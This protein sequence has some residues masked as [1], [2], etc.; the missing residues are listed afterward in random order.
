MLVLTRLAKTV[1]LRI[2]QLQMLANMGEELARQQI[3]A[4]QGVYQ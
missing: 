3:R 2:R 1:K 4:I